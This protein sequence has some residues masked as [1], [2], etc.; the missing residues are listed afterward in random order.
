MLDSFGWTKNLKLKS[1]YWER[2]WVY[3]ENQNPNEWTES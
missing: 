2:D 1:K 3:D